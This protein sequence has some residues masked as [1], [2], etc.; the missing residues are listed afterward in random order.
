MNCWL[1]LRSVFIFSFFL[2][3][4]NLSYAQ[5]KN[6]EERKSIRKAKRQEKIDKGKLMITPLAGPAYTPEL[7]LTLAGGVMISFK[8]NPQ[9]TLIQRSSSPIMAG[10]TTTGAYFI[11]TKLSTFWFKDKLRIY[12]DIN[13][14][15]MPDNYWGVGYEEGY[16]TKKGETTTAY[17]RTWFQLNPKFLWQFKKNLFIGPLLDFNYTRGSDACDSVH[18]DT[19]YQKYN[20]RPYN[21]GGGLIFQYDNRDV[22]VNAW[23]G[24]LIEVSATFYGPYLGGQ[25]TYQVYLTDIRKYFRIKKDGR[26]LALQLKGRFGFG[27]VPYGEMSQPGTPF[28][29]RGYIWGQYRDESMVIFISEYRHQFYKKNGKLSA[30]GLVGWVGIGSLGDRVRNFENWL[31]CVGIGYRIQVQPRM[32]V[33]L[34]FGIG[35]ESN[36]F[37]LN[38]NEAF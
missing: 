15:D 36:G 6:K 13:F 26:T 1:T 11:G 19:Y 28:D 8:T 12:A 23:T 38:F 20:D 18:A 16:T 29:L 17:D 5:D 35:R 31:P 14:K 7:G 25:N 2:I 34:D 30:H 27:D 22:P 37:Y 21:G 32:N 10:I 9:D 4:F 33:R 24:M 3:I